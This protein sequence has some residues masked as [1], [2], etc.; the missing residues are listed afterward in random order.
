[1]RRIICRYLTVAGFMTR[2]VYPSVIAPIIGTS[3]RLIPS[4]LSVM[5]SWCEHKSG[6]VGGRSHDGGEICDGNEACGFEDAMV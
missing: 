6:E 5:R 3:P 4:R 2:K 1:M